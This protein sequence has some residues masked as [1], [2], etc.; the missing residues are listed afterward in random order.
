MGIYHI[1]WL[2]GFLPSTVS[3]E[4]YTKFIISYHGNSQVP[5]LSHHGISMH[6]LFWRRESQ[7]TNT[8]GFKKITFWNAIKFHGNSSQFQFPPNPPATNTLS[9]LLNP[10]LS[11]WPNGRSYQPT[12][13]PT[14]PTN[15]PNQPNQPNRF[16]KTPCTPLRQVRNRS[17]PE[18]PIHPTT[19]DRSVT[20]EPRC[21]ERGSWL[22]GR[23]GVG[24]WC[25][26]VLVV[27]FVRLRSW[28]LR[29][30]FMFLFQQTDGIG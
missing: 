6:K 12:N 8:L 27:G 21:F 3:L 5:R 9:N 23:I 30:F 20:S 11:H 1:N 10:P 17:T 28:V 7:L 18:A 4:D 2:A 16:G 26:G 13:Q 14:Q 25:F 22:K 29:S 19:P 24:G 15:Q